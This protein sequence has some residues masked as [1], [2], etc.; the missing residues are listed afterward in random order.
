MSLRHW[1]AHRMM[2]CS[3][4]LTERPI[5]IEGIAAMKIWEAIA[6]LQDG[7]AALAKQLAAHGDVVT[8]MA[9]ADDLKA[10]SAKVDDLASSVGKRLDGDDAA[11]ASI[12]DQIGTPPADTTVGATG[13]DTLSAGTGTD[14]TIASTGSDTL[15]SAMADLG[16]FTPASGTTGF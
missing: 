13:S 2:R 11:I 10:L 3:L 4:R 9:S 6:A 5:T 15:P 12:T 1:I 7:Q 8:G 16:T 14:T